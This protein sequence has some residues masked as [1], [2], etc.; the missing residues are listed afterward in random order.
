MG[1]EL[2]FNLQL[3]ILSKQKFTVLSYLLI[4]PIS[5]DTEINIQYL[6]DTR[7]DLRKT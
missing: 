2:V 5:C 6:I 3:C 7:K 4:L 1:T